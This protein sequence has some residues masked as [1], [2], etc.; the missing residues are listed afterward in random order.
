MTSQKIARLVVL[1]A[2]G[3]GK[4]AMT[5]Y[6]CH[7]HFVHEYDPTIENSFR[8]HITLD[9]TACCLDILDTAGEEEY[10]AMKDQYM[11]VGEGFLVVYSITDKRSFA[12]IAQFIEQIL[13]LKEFDYAPIVIAGN[14]CDLE[15]ERRVEILE[16]EKVAVKYQAA[17]FET[18]A[19]YGVNIDEAVFALARATIE[20]N[21]TLLS[22]RTENNKSRKKKQCVV[23]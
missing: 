7:H 6:F 10:S 20:F 22:S 4:S 9:E 21:A 17:F 1:G 14:K 13:K 19:K 18:S 5:I 2:G 16:G 15:P 12:E 8:K 3:V 11:R 23:C